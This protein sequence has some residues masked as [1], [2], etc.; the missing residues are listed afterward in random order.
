MDLARFNKCCLAW[1]VVAAGEE[2]EAILFV[3]VAVACLFAFSTTG[4]GKHWAFTRA[5]DCLLVTDEADCGPL[6]VVLVVCRCLL[7]VVVIVA[8]R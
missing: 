8:A 7:A 6:G 2:E 1:P 4:G 3:A 5:Q